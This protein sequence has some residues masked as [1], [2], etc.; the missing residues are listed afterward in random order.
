MANN[1]LSIHIEGG[2]IF[3]QN[4]HTSENFHNFLLAQQDD[5]TALVLK[6]ISYHHSFEK[7]IQNFLPSFSI[8]DAE[9]FDLFAH[10]NAKYLFYRFNDYIKT[11][12]GKRQT[13][14]HTLKVKDSIG[15]NKIEE[16]DLQF[17]V[18]KILH[19]FEFKKLYENSIEKKP[20]ITDTV[21]NSFRIIRRVYQHIYAD[22]AGI[23]FEYIHSLDPDEIQKLED[24]IKTNGWRVI[25]LI[26]TTM[27]W[28]CCQC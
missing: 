27:A 25:N 5:Q 7:Y 22:I 12:G 17:L 16:R 9:K 28:N 15:L 21:E 26:E 4:I 18:E 11:S 14:K 19:A 24:D 10:K 13:I 3:Y 6:R 1:S 8:G 23:F 20:E 2:D